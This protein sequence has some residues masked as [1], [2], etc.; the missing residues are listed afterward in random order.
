MKKHFENLIYFKNKMQKKIYSVVFQYLTEKKEQK[1]YSNPQTNEKQNTF[2]SP[3]NE[4]NVNFNIIRL[5]YKII[6]LEVIRIHLLPIQLAALDM[7]Y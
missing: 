7:K 6:R 1:F 4:I 3:S 5:G 2:S